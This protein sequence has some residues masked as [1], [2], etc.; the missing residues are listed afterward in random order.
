MKDQMKSRLAKL[1]VLVP[2]K[3]KLKALTDY[4]RA[5]DLRRQ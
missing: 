3:S 4:G 5:G 1:A 2:Q